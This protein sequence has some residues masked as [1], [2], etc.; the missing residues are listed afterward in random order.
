MWKEQSPV[1]SSQ[2]YNPSSAMN[3]RELNERSGSDEIR[4]SKN[5]RPITHLG[6]MFSAEFQCYF[7]SNSTH[8]TLPLYPAPKQLLHDIHRAGS[9]FPIFA[10]SVQRCK[11]AG[12]LING[13]LS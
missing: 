9:C 13:R 8:F 10:S 6:G 11:S 7:P 4:T 3:V 2:R 5:Y 1:W 12:S